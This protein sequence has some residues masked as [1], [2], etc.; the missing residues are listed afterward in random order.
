VQR[1]CLQAATSLN[2][3][4]MIVYYENTYLHAI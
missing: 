2:Y 4:Q 1:V 3:Y